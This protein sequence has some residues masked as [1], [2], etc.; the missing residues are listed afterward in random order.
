MSFMQMVPM[1]QKNGKSGP[2]FTEQEA[3][4]LVAVVRATGQNHTMTHVLDVF[5][6]AN[7]RTVRNHHHD[8]LAVHGCGRGLR[9]SSCPLY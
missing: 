8:A 9:Y 6:G 4:D 5:R 2:P 1:G 7:T 3:K